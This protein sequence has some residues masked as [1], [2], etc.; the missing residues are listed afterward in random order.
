MYEALRITFGQK[1]RYEQHTRLPDWACDPDG[2]L[3]IVAN[4]EEEANSLIVKHVGTVNGFVECAGIYGPP[5]WDDFDFY[6]P[7]GR[8]GTI[9]KDGLHE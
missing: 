3:S 8:V 9:D 2:W 1:Y 6:F 4:T 7:H 5:L